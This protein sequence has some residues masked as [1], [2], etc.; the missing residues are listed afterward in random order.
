MMTTRGEPRRVGPARLTVTIMVS[1]M[2]VSAFAQGIVTP[3]FVHK[4][5]HASSADQSGTDKT[6]VV[7]GSTSPVTG[8]MTF[9]TEGIDLS[10]VGTSGTAA[11]VLYVHSVTTAGVVR[12]YLL[13]APVGGPEANVRLSDISVGALSGSAAVSANDAGRMVWLDITHAVGGLGGPFYGI[14]LQG[15]NGIRAEFCSKE[16]V[17]PPLALVTHDIEGATGKWHSG[18]ELPVD[19][20]GDAGDYYLHAGG[21][22]VYAH[23]G[24]RWTLSVTILGASGTDDSRVLRWRGTWTSATVYAAYDVV[25]HLGATYFTEANSLNQSPS[26]RGSPWRRLAA[27]GT[28]GTSWGDG[29]SALT[30]TR[31]VG[32]GEAAP[33]ESLSVAGSARVTGDLIVGGAT[34]ADSI[35]LTE[36]YGLLGSGFEEQA[37][38]P[39]LNAT[40]LEIPGITLPDP[41]VVLRGPGV[42]IDRLEH[43]WH[44]RPSSGEVIRCD[45]SGLSMEPPFIIEVGGIGA[46]N[47]QTYFDAYAA[48]PTLTMVLDLSLVVRARAGDVRVRWNLTGFAPKGYEAGSGGR[49][50]YTF[51]QK[52]APN[53]TWECSLVTSNFTGYSRPAFN[54]STDQPVEI[55]GVIVFA[56]EVAVDT[57]ARTVTLT[58]MAG[59]GC[60]EMATWTSD[61]VSAGTEAGSRKI[62][63]IIELSPT[64][65]GGASEWW[66]SGYYEVGRK[67]YFE[68]FPIKFEVLSGFRLHTT[69]VERVTI[70]YGYREDG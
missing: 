43:S 62:M 67:N 27:W 35:Y 66:G 3:M 49:T 48:F 39:T 47:L 41:V 64:N 69:L 38:D 24:T 10:H 20:V 32:M 5:G 4:D 30:T 60:P 2:A 23:D 31:R 11:L 63:T 28:S 17:L 12:A 13:S 46:T 45:Q 42:E 54:P 57:V 18:N 22:T 8:W 29:A 19:T 37:P 14:A 15:D 53:N 16:G 51:E 65:P 6:V 61:L 9:Q 55:Q 7:D 25:S 34:Q 44:W 56:P 33:A 36:I 58:Y 21:G 70:A 1:L 59:E 40:M 50:R 26:L 52:R 68:C